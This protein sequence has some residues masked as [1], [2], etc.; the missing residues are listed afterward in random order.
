MNHV[1]PQVKKSRVTAVAL[2]MMV[3]LLAG[4]AIQAHAQTFTTLYSFQGPNNHDGS[5]PNGLVQGTNG[6]LYGTTGANAGGVFKITTGGKETVLHVF[7]NVAGDPDGEANGAALVQGSNGIFYG[8]SQGNSGG[9]GGNNGTCGV[10]YKITSAGTFT[11]LYDF[12][13]NNP[14]GECLDGTTTEAAL[15]QASNGDFYGTNNVYGANGQGTIFKITP[16]GKLTTLHAFCATKNQ[17]NYCLDGA[18]PYSALVEGTDGNLYG[19]TTFGGDNNEGTIY[20]ITQ[21]GVFT[22]LHNIGDNGDLGEYPKAA[23][24]QGADGNFYGTTQS[25]GVSTFCVGNCGTFFV[26]TPSGALT[27]LHSFCGQQI[28]VDGAGPQTLMLASDG[29]FYGMTGTGGANSY[30]TIFQITAGGTL[31]TLHS[32]DGTDG[33]VSYDS[34]PSTM[35]I[36]DTGGVFYG[37]TQEGRASSPT[38]AMAAPAQCSAWLWDLNHSLLET[39]PTSGKVGAAVEDFSGDESEGRDQALRS[40]VRQL[41]SRSSPVVWRSRRMCPLARPPAW[42]RL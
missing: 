5:Y 25:G 16:S 38:S 19:T 21:K 3:L 10:F 14:N 34:Y 36:Q 41:L 26:M 39:L 32:F 42:F 24:V 8:T 13:S 7:D 33:V 28:F 40:T 20:R 27:T 11:V 15:V 23:L 29:N 17:N 37:T 35:L 12:C 1:R 31:T 9:C 6:Y 30:G 22:T 4:A 18:P 2:T